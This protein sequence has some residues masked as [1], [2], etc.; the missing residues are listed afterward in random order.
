[1]QTPGLFEAILGSIPQ[2]LCVVNESGEIEWVNAAWAEFARSNS[3]TAQATESNYVDVCDRAAALGDKDALAVGAGIASVIAGEVTSFE[4]EYP[5]HSPTTERWFLMRVSPLLGDGPRPVVI[6]HENITQRRRAE[7]RLREL[8]E[9]DGLTGI[10]NR[11]RLDAFLDGELRR[12]ARLNQPVSII[13]IDLDAFKEF[14]DRFGH[15]AGD[16]YLRE[17]AKVVESFA[18]RPSDLAARYGGE[19]FVVVL[20]NTTLAA[21]EILAGKICEAVPATVDAPV[22]VTVS[23]GVAS[24]H[25]TEAHDAD[26]LLEHADQAMYDAKRAG[27]NRV[28]V[29]R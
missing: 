24:C 12:A 2:H 5:C 20:G 21:S 29:Y 8:A 23:A 25:P 14:N 19:E 18:R 28:G 9:Q 15:S 22:P 26:D 17:T 10:A 6:S 3:G 13:M 16:D 11:R 1:M 4:Y 7:K 27:G